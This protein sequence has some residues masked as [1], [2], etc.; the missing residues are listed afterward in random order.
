LVDGGFF[1][2]CFILQHLFEELG[3]GAFAFCGLA[4][5]GSWGED[6]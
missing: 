2:V 4:D 5:F 6:A 1:C 3:D